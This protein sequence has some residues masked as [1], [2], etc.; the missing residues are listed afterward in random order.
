[1]L[2]KG[3]NFHEYVKIS[4]IL[5]LLSIPFQTIQYGNSVATLLL[6]LNSDCLIGTSFFGIVKFIL[7]N[8]TLIKVKTKGIL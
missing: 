2:Q 1:M 5:M 3:L 4:V 6:F 8:G 7:F